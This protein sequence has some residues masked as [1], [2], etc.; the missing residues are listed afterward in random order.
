MF[1]KLITL[2]LML[3]VFTVQV[4]ASTNNGLKEAFDEFNY[5]LVVEWDQKDASFREAKMKQLSATIRDLQA[6]GLSNAQLIDFAKSEMKDA[7]AAMD[8][9]TAFNMVQINKMSSSEASNYVLD[10]LNKSYFVGA[11]WNGEVVHIAGIVLFLAVVLTALYFSVI[12]PKD[13]VCTQE[14]AYYC[15]TRQTSDCYTDISGD[16]QCGPSYN[17]EWCGTTC[18]AGQDERKY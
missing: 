8:L 4:N 14:S 2:M 17:Y 1:K 16:T 11:S 10:I 5:S 9:E 12:N 6:K 18:V 13:F 15:E 3:S 7:K